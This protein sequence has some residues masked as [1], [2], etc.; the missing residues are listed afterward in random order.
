MGSQPLGLAGGS[1]TRLR[2]HSSPHLLPGNDHLVM[3]TVDGDLLT[4]G[5]GEQGQLG[6]VPAFF[7]DR[8]GRRGLRE[9]LPCSE[10][11]GAVSLT[12]VRAL[13]RS[14]ETQ[15]LPLLLKSSCVNGLFGFSELDLR[16]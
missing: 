3:L 13:Q 10:A 16:V 4:C 9:L 5:C 11:Q 8:G 7:A 15:S 12:P 1:G 2:L 6:R 14:K